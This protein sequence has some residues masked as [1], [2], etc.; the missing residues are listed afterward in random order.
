MLNFI[1]RIGSKIADKVLDNLIVFVLSALVP[2]VVVVYLFLR[3]WLFKSLPVILPVW[4][5]LFVGIGSVCLLIVGIKSRVKIRRRLN[6]P[7]D[8]KN[9]INE[10]LSK[11]DRQIDLPVEEDMQYYFS[12]IDK[13]LGIKRGSSRRYLPMLARQH[14]YALQ[15]GKRT[16]ILIRLLKTND[17][18]NVLKEHRAKGIRHDKEIEVNCKV[19]ARRVGWPI[20][21]IEQ[22][23]I[24]L[25]GE[26]FSNGGKQF[27]VLLT[28]DNR[29]ILKELK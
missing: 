17:I 16:F 12:N 4:A 2:V 21:G 28:K 26:S 24:E 10:W 7:V 22:L 29:V 23:F 20:E 18:M 1:K 14:S 25:E 27:E 11:G 13:E 8:I 9:A 3:T 5:W 6:D 19:V 15:S